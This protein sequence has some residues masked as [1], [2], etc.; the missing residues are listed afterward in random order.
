MNDLVRSKVKDPNTGKTPLWGEIMAGSIAGGS[1]V[2]FTNPLEIVKIRLQGAFLSVHFQ[3]PAI[4]VDILAFISSVQGEAASKG[5]LEGPRRSAIW[6]VK[7]LGLFGLYK[8][9]GACL[10]R[11]IPFSGIYFPVYAHLKTDMFHEGRNGKK[12][13]IWEVYISSCCGVIVGM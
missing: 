3:F 12:L 4:N 10:L 11:D 1:Q 13:A 2:I 8:G 7:N 6:I 5:A 9:A